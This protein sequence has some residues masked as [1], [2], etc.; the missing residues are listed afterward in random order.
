MIEI[1]TVIET[2]RQYDKLEEIKKILELKNMLLAIT[3]ENRSL[4]TKIDGLEKK[5]EIK[6]KLK[7]NKNH[8]EYED[9]KICSTCYDSERLLITLIPKDN[10]NVRFACNYC[11][12]VVVDN[13]LASKEYQTAVSMFLQNQPN[14]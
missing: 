12:N 6:N 7:F 10:N 4:R 11:K 2:L 13:Q 14:W 3:E 5:L 9:R 8:Y 1:K